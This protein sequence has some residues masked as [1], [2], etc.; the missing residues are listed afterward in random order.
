MCLLP[1]KSLSVGRLDDRSVVYSHSRS[2]SGRMQK[3]YDPKRTGCSVGLP[4]LVSREL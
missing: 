2:L 3:S 4:N 1:E